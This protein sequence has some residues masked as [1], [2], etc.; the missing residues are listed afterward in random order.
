M[1]NFIYLLIDDLDDIGNVDY[2]FASTIS[3]SRVVSIS[4]PSMV[5]SL[6]HVIILVLVT[7]ELLGCL[8]TSPQGPVSK[9]YLFDD[10]SS[11]I[12]VQ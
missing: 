11:S 6:S 8:G 1:S 12:I 5:S 4:I 7:D 10:V 2:F 9:S 3:V